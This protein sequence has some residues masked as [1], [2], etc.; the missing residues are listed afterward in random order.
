MQKMYHH[1]IKLKVRP[2]FNCNIRISE[3]KTLLVYGTVYDVIKIDNFFCTNFKL[4]TLNI[5]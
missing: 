3:V 1:K 4:F 2:V 5:K